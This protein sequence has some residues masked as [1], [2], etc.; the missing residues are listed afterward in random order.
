[1]IHKVE[2]HPVPTEMQRKAG[3]KTHAMKSRYPVLAPLSDPKYSHHLVAIATATSPAR[4][5]SAA[6][7]MV[8]LVFLVFIVMVV[9]MMG[10]RMA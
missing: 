9:M 10:S 4:S 2:A 7:A 3:G 6:V 8:F 1:M 5:R